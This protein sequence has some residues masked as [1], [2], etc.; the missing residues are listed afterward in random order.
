[1]KELPII[2]FADEATWEQWLSENQANIPDGIWLKLAKKNAQPSS[3]SYAQAL[4]VALCYGWIDGKKQSLD[5]THWLQHFVPRR[6]KSPWSAVNRDKVAVLIA[7]GR[8]Q[9]A[10]Q[11]E[12]DAAKADGRWDVAY[13]PQSQ[14]VIPD[15]LIAALEQNPT[16]KAFFETLNKANRYAMVYRLNDAK[17][18]ETRQKRLNEFIQMLSDGKKLH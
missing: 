6:K 4:D 18:P 9:P 15:D 12:I 10:G 3:V 16:A 5:D 7:Q 1:M 2:L 13:A 17:K 14:M 8:M 11:R